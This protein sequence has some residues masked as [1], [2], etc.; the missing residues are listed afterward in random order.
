MF[1]MFVMKFNFLGLYFLIYQTRFNA[2][3]DDFKEAAMID[4]ASNLRIFLTI[5]V[6]MTKTTFFMVFMMHFMGFWSDYMTPLIYVET[7]PT[8][9]LGLFRFKNS[10]ENALSICA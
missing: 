8:M 1:G 3:S 5:M 2:I 4:G 7:R 6:P 10:S 9:A